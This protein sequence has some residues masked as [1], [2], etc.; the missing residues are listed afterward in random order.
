MATVIDTSVWIDFFHPETSAAVRGF[1]RQVLDSD[2]IYSCAPVLFE[3]LRSAPEKQQRSLS[4]F[5][6]TVPELPI[7]P[8]LWSEATKLGQICS[9]QGL[10]IRSLD[11]LIAQCC[12]A[13]RLSVT[14]F[15][16]DF[17]LLAKVCSLKVN[18]LKKPV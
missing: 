17:L 3:L 11:L 13:S 4:D 15:D 8:N 5:F 16:Q 1:I 14:T 7:S 10:S 9:R 6:T 12:L 2:D 18:F